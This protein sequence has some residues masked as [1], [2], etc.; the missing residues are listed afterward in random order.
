[1]LK[2]HRRKVALFVI[3]IAMISNSGCESFQRKFTRRPKQ[4]PKP[5]T[6]V[7]AF[8]DYSGAMTP[9][10]RYR[11]HYVMFDYWNQDLIDALQARSPNPKRYCRSSEEAIIEL[12]TMQSLLLDASAQS[13]GPLIE[14]REKT[15]Q[16][17]QSQEYR[18][19]A[20]VGITVR[21]VELQTRDIHRQFF[22]RDIQE[23]L[24]A[25]AAADAAA[26]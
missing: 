26:H 5:P 13:L 3:L 18:D 16:Q 7:I 22:W 2:Q 4:A 12:K 23:Q 11:K 20:Q 25:G 24:K 1:M 21:Q 17:I 19:Q 14:K 6:P 9:L 10:E 8:Q 15:N